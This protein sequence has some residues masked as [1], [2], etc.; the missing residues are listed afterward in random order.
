MITSLRQASPESSGVP[1]AVDWHGTRPVG[2]EPGV[3]RLAGCVAGI[4]PAARAARAV[5][6]ARNMGRV[7]ACR[8]CS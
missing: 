5:F 7:S 8:W 4:Q 3:R 2:R 1:E 6:M